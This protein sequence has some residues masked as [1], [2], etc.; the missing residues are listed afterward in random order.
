MTVRGAA[1]SLTVSKAKV[2]A[3]REEEDSEAITAVAHPAKKPS[4]RKKKA[5]QG[6]SGAPRRK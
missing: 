6:P 2:A 4:E 1:F 5:A 3:I